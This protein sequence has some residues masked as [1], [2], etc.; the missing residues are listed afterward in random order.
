MHIRALR[1]FHHRVGDPLPQIVGDN[2]P[3]VILIHKV[4]NHVVSPES[5]DNEHQLVIVCLLGGIEV[6]LLP[7]LWR[8]ITTDLRIMSL[9]EPGLIPDTKKGAHILA[10]FASL[11]TSDARK[12]ATEPHGMK[13]IISELKI[14]SKDDLVEEIRSATIAT[15]NMRFPTKDQTDDTICKS[16]SVHHGLRGNE[17]PREPALPRL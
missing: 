3:Q 13:A 5:R 16:G 4:T 14:E 1:P 10:G 9:R 15:M 6:R 11:E 7:E 2:I 17:A 12:I 8:F